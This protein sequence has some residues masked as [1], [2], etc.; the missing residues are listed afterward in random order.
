M[1]GCVGI[2]S[3][4]LQPEKSHSLIHELAVGTRVD[5]NFFHEFYALESTESLRSVTISTNYDRIFDISKQKS[6]YDYSERSEP[7]VNKYGE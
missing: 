7:L 4:K 3:C 1:T 5:S 2:I 6:N